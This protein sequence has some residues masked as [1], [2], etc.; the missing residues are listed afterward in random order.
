MAFA[1]P[2][3]LNDGQASPVAHNFAL[4]FADAKEGKRVDPATA[5]PLVLNL[6][7]KH[8]TQGSA[9]DA[10]FADR[11]LLQVVYSELDAVGRP[12]Y[13]I[14]NH[15]VTIW[16]GVSAATM[17]PRVNDVLAYDRNFFSVTGNVDKWL[18]GQM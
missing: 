7:I 9:K 2:L 14:S 17:R 12:Q 8:A 3:V 5:A 15:T 10:S 6:S 11:R 16:R 4:L 18:S 13:I 1:D